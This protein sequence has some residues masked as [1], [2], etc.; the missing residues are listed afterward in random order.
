MRL[1]P[2]AKPEM[3]IEHGDRNGVRKLCHILAYQCEATWTIDCVCTCSD[4]VAVAS[5]PAPA[6]NAARS[7]FNDATCASAS[8]RK[9]YT[10]VE[11]SA[12]EIPCKPQPKHITCEAA[13]ASD[14]FCRHLLRLQLLTQLVHLACCLNPLHLCFVQPGQDQAITSAVNSRVVCECADDPTTP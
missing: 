13:K 6:W 1:L 8:F 7:A 3:D 2:S 9:F 12:S 11:F 10:D 14:R 4:D 5:A